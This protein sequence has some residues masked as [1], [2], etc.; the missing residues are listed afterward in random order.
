MSDTAEPIEYASRASTTDLPADRLLRRAVG[1]TAVLY[2]GQAVLATAL[3][4]ALARRWLRTPPNMSW[5]VPTGWTM[6]ASRAQ[7]LAMAGILVAGVLLLRR[8]PLAVHVLRG[9][10]AGSIVLSIVNLGLALANNPIYA[11]YWST[12]GSFAIEALY[13]LGGLWLP[14]LLILITLPSLARR[15]V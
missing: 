7:T 10:V 6:I 12:P 4:I 2:G 8:A 14:L 3:H 11:S 5:D 15:M 13:N 9:C 1:W